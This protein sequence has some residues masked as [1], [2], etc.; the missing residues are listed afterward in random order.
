MIPINEELRT[1]YE[2]ARKGSTRPSP[3]HV[4]LLL[5]DI[6]KENSKKAEIYSYVAL[7][8]K[9][10]LAYR[11]KNKTEGKLF[12][13]KLIRLEYKFPRQICFGVEALKNALESYK[14]YVSKDYGKAEILM[15]SAIKNSISQSKENP[16]FI[17]SAFEQ[18][19][20]LVRLLVTIED[21][22]RVDEEITA[23]LYFIMRKPKYDQL[24]YNH[25]V[26]DLLNEIN[27]EDIT[28]QYFYMLETIFIK[29]KGC[30]QTALLINHQ[31]KIL[32]ENTLFYDFVTLI[33]E[34][35]QFHQPKECLDYYPLFPKNAKRY[36]DGFFQ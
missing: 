11:S 28:R 15:Y 32:K 23:F 17:T 7:I 20:N 33:S 25:E 12:F 18:W 9:S 5:A 27:K 24:L 35:S 22:K 36:V 29:L 2:K 8:E 13:E 34:G 4:G 14:E 6:V 26:L 10:I 16:L 3:L 1:T 19:I 30:R 21:F 31:E